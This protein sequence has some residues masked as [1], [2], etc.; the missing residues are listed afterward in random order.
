MIGTTEETSPEQMDEQNVDLVMLALTTLIT[1]QTDGSEVKQ[2]LLRNSTATA[3]SIRTQIDR[4]TQI[5]LVN[6]DGEEIVRVVDPRA[7]WSTFGR[8]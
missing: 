1:Q 7:K 8:E 6:Q 4:A 2:E 3:I 5:I